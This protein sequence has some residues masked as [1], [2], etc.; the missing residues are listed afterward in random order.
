[1]KEFSG[2]RRL[3][4]FEIKLMPEVFF[5]LLLYKIKVSLFPSKKYLPKKIERS[6]SLTEHKK[7]QGNSVARII[8][9]ISIRIPWSTTC[10]IKVLAANKMLVKRDIPHIIHF[11]VKK[12]SDYKMEAHAWLSVNGKVL[13]GGENRSG[14][15]ELYQIKG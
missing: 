6:G 4:E 1:M 8:N 13:I 3:T 7:I 2:L 11:G 12:S 15:Q 9:G 14:F 10:L 5:N